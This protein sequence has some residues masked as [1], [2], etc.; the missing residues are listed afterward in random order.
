MNSN[1]REF[2]KEISTL[3]QMES[4]L[5]SLKD[6]A[7]ASAQEALKAQLQVVR[8]I[9][10]PTLIDTTFDTLILR[11]K[12]SLK[13]AENEGQKEQI[14]EAFSLMI[15]NYVFF[16]DARLQYAINENKE[17]ARLL[18]LQAGE[19]LSNSVKRVALL[20][21]NGSEIGEI[22]SVIVHNLFD[23][24]DDASAI[25]LFNRLWKWWNKDKIIVEKRHE[26]YITLYGMC[27]KLGKYQ[28]M[29]GKSLIISGMI[30]RYTPDISEYA[31]QL[32]SKGVDIA[33]WQGLT[34]K[35]IKR[36]KKVTRGKQLKRWAWRIST[37][38]GVLAAIIVSLIV[39]IIREIAIEIEGIANDNTWISEQIYWTIGVIGVILVVFF[40]V[41]I[42]MVRNK[43][44][45]A[46]AQTIE[47][48]LKQIADF[49][50]EI[51]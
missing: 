8:F 5:I 13:K 48:E 50:N 21:V 3:E 34:I 42:N 39:G 38:I 9:Q 4:W 18:F 33:N 40:V 30:E 49:Y 17:E 35:D 15:Q 7:N 2:P 46:K 24:S 41:E 1:M 10:S 27:K 37:V 45:I 20:A 23:E 44:M 11:L 51:G 29:I 6:G 22:A 31:H 43:R 28:P 14:R 16:F 19:M 12:T 26:F 32:A 25:S 47:E 36:I